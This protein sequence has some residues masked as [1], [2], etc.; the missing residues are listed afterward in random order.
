ME[1]V[2]LVERHDGWTTLTLNRPDRLNSFNIELHKL[3]AAAFNDI[4]DDE[5]CRAVILTGAGRGFC[6]GQD[7]SDR[8]GREGPFDLGATLDAWYNPLVRRIRSLRKPVICA[9]NGVAA[10]AGA[11]LALACDI[12]IAAR[13]AKFL[14]A[15][16]KIGLVPDCGGTY[17]LPRLI[18]DARARA[19]MM[20]AEPITAETAESWGLIWKVVDDAVLM[21]QAGAMAAHL[22][23]QPT[24]AFALIKDALNIGGTN[25]L[26]TQLDLERDLQRKAGLSPDFKEGVA[27][28]MEKRP[29]RFTGRAS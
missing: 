23:T 8:A 16:A 7:L 29:A 15:F 17:F 22:A 26:S 20:L 2:L 24:A 25:D 9:V 1:D 19:L 28:F 27:A 21:E 3:L 18:G 6:A 5:T 10:G 14:Q 12:V 4:A 11:N 13:S